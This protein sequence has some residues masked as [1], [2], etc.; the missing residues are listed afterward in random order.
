MK[1]RVEKLRRG[2]VA[3]PARPPARAQPEADFTAEGAPPPGKVGAEHPALPAAE[4][5]P[6]GTDAAGKP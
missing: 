6:G 3:T 5:A 2:H 4:R 1:L